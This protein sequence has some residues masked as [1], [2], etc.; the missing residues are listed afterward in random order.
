MKI[1]W[2]KFKHR[3]LTKV[4]LGY[5]VVAWVLIQVIEAVLPTFETPLWVAQTITFLL[6]LGFPIAILVGWA[7]EKLPISST[8]SAEE[9]TPQ[10]AHET[11]RR[12]LVWIGVGSCV[13]VGLFG[14]YMMP[15]IF[16]Q[17][18]FQ[19]SE[20]ALTPPGIASNAGR[21]SSVKYEIDVGDTGTRGWG[22]RSDIAISSD[23]R[24]LVFTEFDRPD[25]NLWIKDLNSF[26]DSR[27]LATADM[28]SETGYP[29]FSE[30]G[31]WIYFHDDGALVRVRREGGT[32]Q[33][34]IQGSVAPS[35]V[36][37]RGQT[38]VFNDVTDSQLK[39]FDINTGIAAPLFGDSNNSLNYTWP[40]FL[41]DSNRLIATR[42]SRTQ[43]GDAS[44]DLID[45]DN[46][47]IRVV[48]PVGYKGRF[49]ASG[50]I[51]FVRG[52]ALWAQP[53]DLDN[54]QNSGDAVPIVF[55]LEV[56]EQFGN[57][58]YTFSNYGRL[59]YVSGDLVGGNFIDTPPVLVDRLGNEREIE[60]D[61]QYFL[62]PQLDPTNNFLA[63]NG[64][65]TAESGFDIWLYDFNSQTLGRR[66]FD[67]QGSR[68]IWSMDG[69]RLIY[70][71]GTGG[72][73]S[74]AANGTDTAISLADGLALPTPYAQ[75]DDSK[76]LIGMGTPP[77]IFLM[78]FSN[79]AETLLQN[80]NLSP[81][82]SGD[83]R[84]SNDSN[85]IAYASDETGREEIY[86]RP[87]PDV[88]SGK[89]QVSRQ[90]GRF[91]VWNGSTNEMFW[92]S[93]DT[94]EIMAATYQVE[95]GP[96]NIIRFSNPTGLFESRYRFSVNFYPYDYNSS[97]NE[98]VFI[99]SDSSNSGSDILNQQTKL[100]V[101]E[102]WFG[103]IRAL[104]PVTVTLN[105]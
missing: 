5:A 94:G 22:S 49:L 46:G 65:A 50:H 75:V 102:D 62:W 103:E 63:L 18:A 34:V 84:L 15:F 13:V 100:K 25:L 29:V 17:N 26:D 6:I 55:D 82:A 93:V 9:T 88:N 37:V 51:V 20:G 79:E 31:Q 71:C 56:Y 30:D 40:Q 61:S 3:T 52:E 64:R 76:L 43:Y 36:A 12:T 47:D 14:F 8:S 10:L 97:S 58:G 101:I 24:Y 77:E 89:W 11:S 21:L 105:Q 33:V 70:R 92:W 81:S 32:P 95:E 7:S 53:V 59:V 42:G 98:F 60:I 16:D 80:L 38:V 72:I 4:F 86:V 23:G 66:S 1:Q 87:Y 83:A 28:N 39:K 74:T 68:A 35:G 19:S 41:P 99:G 67:S 2:E 91:P 54:F 85:W 44:I 27:L 104:A 57:A 78:D 48:A 90:G 73:C 69:S 45:L 96:L